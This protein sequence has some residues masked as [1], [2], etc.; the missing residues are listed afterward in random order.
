MKSLHSRT[1][2]KELLIGGVLIGVGI[3][4]FAGTYLRATGYPPKRIYLEALVGGALF[5]FGGVRLCMLALRGEE[6]K[7]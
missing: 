2:L 5:V 1:A 4:F 6:R 7:G 3:A